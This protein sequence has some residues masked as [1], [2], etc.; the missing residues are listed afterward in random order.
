MIAPI[1][2]SL[3][4]QSPIQAAVS[5]LQFGAGIADMQAARQDREIKTQ[6]QA[7][8]LEAN[9]RAME[10]QRLQNELVMKLAENKNPTGADYE[11]ATLL[12]PSQRE[13]FKQAWDMHTADAQK[14][15]LEEIT[16][17]HAA[18]TTG[19]PEVAAG[20]LER[21]I[22]SL[23]NSDGPKDQIDAA[24]FMV[25]SI[26]N[27]PDLA[28][29]KTGLKLGAIPG[30]KDALDTINK[31]A[32]AQREEALGKPLLSEAESKAKSAAAAAGFAES[33]EAMKFQKEGWDIAKIQNDIAVSK[34]N[35]RIAAIN[36]QISKESNVLK[37]EEL[38]L[39]L[40]EMRDKRDEVVRDRT[41]KATEAFSAIDNS[42]NTI[43][44]LL[45]SPGLADVTGAIQGAPY[46]PAIVAGAI[47]PF[48]ATADERAD[49]VA[50]LETFGSQI[51]LA[52]VREA[53]SM[54]GL[55]EK[56]GE[57]LQS[58]FIAA[59]RRQSDKTVRENLQEASR[60]LMKG[61]ENAAK[62]FGIPQS[63]PDTPAAAGARP[64]QKNTDD[65][66]RELGVLR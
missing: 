18:L 47:Q 36:A 27:S 14:S 53:G 8:A 31:I 50:N 9:R 23:K 59:S 16:S 12:V 15:A 62:K 55:T 32:Q 56:E 64:G 25:D 13:Q 28:R 60:L 54:A 42:L 6:Q 20:I 19:N 30:G 29:V 35:A 17:V 38:G 61:R 45:K 33:A 10:Q 57:K 2:Y 24:Q 52:K 66:L 63:I 40:G 44:K 65:I 26:K 37:R 49:A 48:G 41:S 46:Y 22:E 58:S 7:Q 34:E 11:R 39:K 51:F 3:D 43:E 21:R 4:V 5:G 1:N